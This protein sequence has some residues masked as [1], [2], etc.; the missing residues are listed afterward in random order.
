MSNREL[1]LATALRLFNE[2]GSHAVSTN[3]IAEQAQVSVGNLYY[4]FRSKEDL[5]RAL[6]EQLNDAWKTRL[7]VPNPM[8]VTWDDLRSLI[9]EH[10]AIVWQ[11]RFFYR[12]Q[13]ALRQNDRVLTR[14]WNEANSRGRADMGMLLLSY[15]ATIGRPTLPEH[16]VARLTDTCWLIADF[17]L[18]HHEMR[19]GPVRR[20][21]LEQGVELFAS[22]MRPLI[23]ATV[24]A[25][26]PTGTPCTDDAAVPQSPSA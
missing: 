10:F 17:W 16:D 1:C 23:A 9:A 20:Q 25:H 5:V 11:F 15:C 26:P 18:V 21:D 19:T 12:E 22:I 6:F 13:V 14:R 7:T 3:L 8:R 2:Q 4:H 24:P